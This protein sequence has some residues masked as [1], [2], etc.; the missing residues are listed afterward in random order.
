MH[1]M[2]LTHG[3]PAKQSTTP[4]LGL[5]LTAL[6]VILL[7]FRPLAEYLVSRDSV[8]IANLIILTSAALAYGLRSR[9]R[10]QKARYR[11]FYLV[12][13]CGV[14]SASSLAAQASAGPTA[15]ELYMVIGT[16]LSFLVL[17]FACDSR[18]GA[19]ATTVVL[20][21]C[22]AVNSGIG[23]W[24]AVTRRTLFNVS[25]EIVGTGAFGYDAVTGR[26]G[27]ITGENYVGMYD[28][29]ALLA[30]LYLIGHRRFRWLGIVLTLL[31]SAAIAVS[32]SRTSVLSAVAAALVFIGVR[33]RKRRSAVLLCG[34]VAALFYF[35]SGYI[36][37]PDGVSSMADEA[38]LI[39][40]RWSTQGV[41]RDSRLDIWRSYLDDIYSYPLFG[42]GSGYLLGAV[43]RGAKVPHNSFLDVLVEFGVTG[44]VFYLLAFVAVYRNWRRAQRR[45]GSILPT[46]LW[47]VF[48]GMA[49]SLLTLSLPLARLL[50][51]V[52]GAV[53]GLV[54]WPAE[55]PRY[56]LLRIVVP[57]RVP[58]QPH[59]SCQFPAT[60]PQGAR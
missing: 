2:K 59:S 31:S 27:G 4:V 7:Y 3:A 60:L 36:T 34:I 32:I 26:A 13:A 42:K 48:C 23:L 33:F 38:S 52:A 6:Y 29:P 58:D 14:I 10:L 19:I 51:A 49:T 21:V 9:V 43:A 16:W 8:Q 35:G 18:P 47:A 40:Y 28:L 20:V 50:W 15:I 41:E 56:R 24:G 11:I 30:G 5:S 53:T 37:N 44:L 57:K 12:A 22:A 55:Q 45:T 39:R 54:D 46:L 1:A 17:A 25:R